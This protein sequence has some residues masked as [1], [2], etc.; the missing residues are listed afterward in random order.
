[1]EREGGLMF[2]SVKFGQNP[3]GNV[4]RIG[5][6]PNGRAV[7]QVIDSDGREAGKLS[8]PAADTD[9]FEKAYI[10]IMETAPQIQ[11][12]VLENSSEKD[13]KRRRNISRAIVAGG[14]IIGAAV[15]MALTRKAS[16]LKQIL[17]T[18]FGIVAG[19]SGGYLAA[20]SAT[21]PPGTFK[22]AKASRTFSK[23]DIQPMIEN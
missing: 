3:Y 10:D 20:I 18:V 4:R 1:M 21:T 13:I 22:F 2:D 8:I 23:I 16:T 7:Y 17:A 19:L 12:Y 15:P 11:K 5:A 6:T 9:K 14:G